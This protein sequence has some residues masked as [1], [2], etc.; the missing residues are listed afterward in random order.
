MTKPAQNLGAYMTLRVTSATLKAFH[1]RARL[2]GKPAEVHRE[3]IDAFIEG[4]LTIKPPK[5]INQESLYV[6]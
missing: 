1:D 4:R 6:N 5:S 3:I 2:F